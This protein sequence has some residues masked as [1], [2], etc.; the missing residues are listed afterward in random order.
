MKVT[1]WNA[2]PP[3]FSRILGS[4]HTC[5]KAAHDN[6][7]ILNK[8]PPPPP[9]PPPLPPHIRQAQYGDYELAVPNR[10][11]CVGVGTTHID[12]EVSCSVLS[13]IFDV[14]TGAKAFAR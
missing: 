2:Y 8:T 12:N 13:P 7:E 6:N 10:G 9:P 4:P 1:R 14:L 11:W 5:F 3:T